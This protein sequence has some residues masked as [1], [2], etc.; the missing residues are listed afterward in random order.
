M[1]RETFDRISQE[2][3]DLSEKI[4]KEKRPAYTVGSTNVL[5]NFDSIGKKLGI[6]PG[7]IAF[8]YFTKHVDAIAN[9]FK[10][11]YQD[12]EPI[13]TRFADAMSYLKLMYAIAKRRDVTIN[14]PF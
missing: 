1:D 10:G 3:H 4:M 13:G 6:D 7:T 8:V 2:L 9:F 12:P 11:G 14:S 5:E